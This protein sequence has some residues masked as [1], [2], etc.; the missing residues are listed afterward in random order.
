MKTLTTIAKNNNLKYRQLRDKL[1]ELNIIYKGK[2]RYVPTQLAL[3]KG[4]AKESG[5]YGNE[6]V[7][8]ISYHYD[9]DMVME[10]YKSNIK[11][12]IEIDDSLPF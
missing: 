7:L 6:M 2:K 1:V 9:E 4:I 8:S 11:L 5:R 12:W 10:H 3:E